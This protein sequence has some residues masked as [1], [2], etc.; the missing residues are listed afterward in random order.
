M[1]KRKLLL[2][3]LFIITTA[4]LGFALYWVFFAPK[5]A[6]EPTGTKT[7]PGQTAT[8]QFPSGGAAQPGTTGTTGGTTQP[9]QGTQP[10]TGAVT[11]P[12]VQPRLTQVLDE[13]ITN[14]TPDKNGGAKF[15][16]VSD[17]KFYRVNPNGSVT[18]LSDQVFYN[19]QKVTWSPIS[20]ESII[21]YPDGAKI[22][23]NFDTNKQVT[24]PK[25]WQE[26]SFSSDG[27]KI[28]AKSI[29]L[30]PENRWL[31]TA[32]PDGGN[33]TLV[34]PMGENEGKVT[35][36]WSPNKQVVALSRTGE[37]LDADREEVLFVGLNGENFRSTVVEGRG[38]VTD[39]SPQGNKLLYSVYSQ[40]SDFKPELWIVNAQGDN[41]GSG[42][43]FLNLNTWADKCTFADER[44]VYC[45]VP[46][47][48]DTGAGFDP[49]LAANTPDKIMKIDLQTGSKTELKADGDH[50][51]N[52][53]FVGA[54]GK[55]LFFTDKQQSGLFKVAL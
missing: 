4:L 53:M 8:D 32:D 5:A 29:G 55:T 33:V 31:V 36:A 1:D 35:V 14:P 46:V 37:P 11:T 39:W 12:T 51:V 2:I 9:T 7:I 28:A 52:S 3:L 47:A 41:I 50:I 38:L 40:R 25:H 17:G 26:F 15:Y 13:P 19:V 54:D 16:S 49:T 22:Y 20:D 24:I 18:A 27:A 30:A 21:E 45:G 43:K 6:P 44:F 23:Y 10:T 34:E 42:R 48:L